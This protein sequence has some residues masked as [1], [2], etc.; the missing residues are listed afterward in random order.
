MVGGVESD[1]GDGKRGDNVAELTY[2]TKVINCIIF[3]L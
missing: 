2:T 1:V 3:L